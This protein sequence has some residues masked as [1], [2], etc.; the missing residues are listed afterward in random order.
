MSGHWRKQ[1]KKCESKK[2]YESLSEALRFIEEAEKEH[3]T[4]DRKGKR[5]PLRP[6]ICKVCK[7]IHVG[8]IPQQEWL[9]IQKGEGTETIMGKRIL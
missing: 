7:K 3:N 5:R 4:P 9:R 1:T 2:A 8:H 6:Y